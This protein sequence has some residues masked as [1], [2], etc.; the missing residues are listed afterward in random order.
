MCILV[1][2][3]ASTTFIIKLQNFSTTMFPEEFITASSTYN[4]C[5]ILYNKYTP[6]TNNHLSSS[7]YITTIILNI[8]KKKAQRENIAQ[9]QY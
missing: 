7:I 5:I 6:I 1:Y 3:T 8:K 9:Q 2:Q 4:F